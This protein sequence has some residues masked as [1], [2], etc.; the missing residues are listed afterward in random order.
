MKGASS[1]KERNQKVSL[2]WFFG[3]NQ[4]NE[5]NMDCWQGARSFSAVK[6]FFVYIYFFIYVFAWDCVWADSISTLFNNEK[7]HFDLKGKYWEVLICKRKLEYVTL[8]CPT[9]FSS[10]LKNTNLQWRTLLV[11]KNANILFNPWTIF[12]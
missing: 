11:R 6:I 7:Q 12:L 5:Y 8:L 3:R 10:P 1:I 4:I 2:K 9:A